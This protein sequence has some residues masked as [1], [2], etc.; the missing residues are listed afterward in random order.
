MIV[1]S[2]GRLS[3]MKKKKKKKKRR[4]KELVF[5]F[6][7]CY[8]S[9]EKKKRSFEDCN[10]LKQCGYVYYFMM[11]T[12][13]KTLLCY[14]HWGRKNK[15]LPDGSI[16]YTRGITDQIIISTGIKYNDF[17]NAVFGR[18]VIDPSDKI[19]HFTVKFDRSELIRLRDQEGVD[20]LLQ[21]N[22]SFAHVYASSLEE[23][24]N[25]VPPSGGAKKVELIVY[26][27]SKPDKTP[28][29][30]D[31]ND[32]ASLLKKARSNQSTGDSK[33]L[34]KA[35]AHQSAGDSKPQQKEDVGGDNQRH[36]CAARPCSNSVERLNQNGLGCPERDVQTN[37]FKIGTVN[38][39]AS[40]PPS[41]GA[42]NIELLVD[43]D[44][45]P[46]TI[47]DSNPALVYDYPDPEFSDF[48]KHKAENRF[49]IDQIWACYDTE[50]VGSR[51]IQK[52]KEAELGSGQSC[53]L[54]V[55]NLNVGVLIPL[56]IDLHFLIKFS[57]RW[58]REV[59][60]HRK[61]KYEVVEILSDYVGDVGVQVGYL[62]KVTGFVSLFQRTMLTEGVPAGSFEL[63]PYSLP[64]NP[65]DIWY[66]GKGKEGSR[67]ANS[68]PVE[69]LLPEVPLGTRDE[70][71]NATPSPKSR[72]L[73]GIHATDGES[74][75]VRIS[76]K[77]VNIS[78]KKRTQMSSHS[79]NDSPSSD[80]DDNY[81]KKC[82][83]SSPSIPSHLSCQADK[84][85]H[86]RIQSFGLSNSFGSSKSPI[87]LS[88]Y[89][90]PYFDFFDKI[91]KESRYSSHSL[92]IHLSC[93]IDRELHSRIQSFGLS[94]SFGSSKSPIALKVSS[95]SVSNNRFGFVIY[96]RKGEI[97]APYKNWKKSGLDPDKLEYEIVEIIE[98]SIDGIIVSSM[99]RVNGF[100]SVFA[101]PGKQ[102]SNSV[103]L[104]IKKDELGR[105]S[106][107]IPAFQLTGEKGGVLRGCW[108]PDPASVPCSL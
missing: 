11:G 53:L 52:I 86:S 26:S 77:E 101:C 5:S 25:S 65:N 102:R 89:D 49:A 78:K 70:S 43:S 34:K 15:V 97:W 17:V 42:K 44:S 60:T 76:P 9:Q 32:L 83:H 38:G 54:A 4:R 50:D 22:D 47:S 88:A 8:P 19:L 21:F 82:R 80:F 94:N 12:E 13:D 36:A 64:L 16:S 39:Q 103:I 104:E 46:D 31:E 41:G 10:H 81:V 66:P 57:A 30:D 28:A 73:N 23:E 93:Q 3:S 63:H 48:D 75:K 45:E 55:G 40:R 67:T 74:A 59:C 72:D 91:V 1:C 35:W 20:T 58:A 7:D 69:N 51:L 62:G 61:Y 85:L 84:E 95:R 18:L 106:H 68:E 14:C 96:P 37:N 29:C 87:A 24:P 99:V 98:N 2:R 56:L 105:L 107:Q 108:E 92:P 100:K 71:R 6:P 79:A 90:S 33:S 27:N